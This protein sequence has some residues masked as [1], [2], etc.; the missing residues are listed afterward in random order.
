MPI[1]LSLLS[2]RAHD[3]KL[4]LT[5]HA[6]GAEFASSYHAYGAYWIGHLLQICLAVL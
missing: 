6:H 2:G 5:Y 3:A 1:M 4:L